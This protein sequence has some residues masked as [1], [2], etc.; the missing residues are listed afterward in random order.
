MQI[1]LDADTLLEFFRNRSDG[2]NSSKE[3]AILR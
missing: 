1:L 2:K 3:I